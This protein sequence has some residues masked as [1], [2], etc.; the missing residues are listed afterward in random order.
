MIIHFTLVLVLKASPTRS[1]RARILYSAW[2]RIYQIKYIPYDMYILGPFSIPEMKVCS[3]ETLRLS[4]QY[5]AILN[6][7]KE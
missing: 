5:R 1:P 7:H 2:A 3:R 6:L 4:T